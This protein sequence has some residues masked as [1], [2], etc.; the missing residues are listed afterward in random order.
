MH[1][2]EEGVYLP[3]LRPGPG[4][5]RDA[6]KR[7]LIKEVLTEDMQN[8]GG[9]EGRGAQSAG[10]MKVHHPHNPTSGIATIGEGSQLSKTI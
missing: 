9:G 4:A 6:G 1:W 7:I 5:G 3:L 2:R 8:G 10:P